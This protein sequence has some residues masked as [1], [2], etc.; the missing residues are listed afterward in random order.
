RGCTADTECS[1]TTPACATGASDPQKGKCVQCT[2]NA[3]CTAPQVCNTT[4]DTCG[5]K[6]TGGCKTNSDCS[7]NPSTPICSTGTC[8]GCAT[9]GD[10][11]DTTK[12]ACDPATKV[13]VACPAGTTCG[14]PGGP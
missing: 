9:N 5:T 3:N 11:T 6:A 14:I 1:G 10:C 2:A 13:C 7:G 4:L 12:S 8:V